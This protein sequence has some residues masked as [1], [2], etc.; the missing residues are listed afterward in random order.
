MTGL[1]VILSFALFLGGILLLGNAFLF[2]ALGGFI[3]F[4]GILAISL[5]LGVAFHI[6]P[7]SQ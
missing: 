3:F 6:L 7:K 2:P 1:G 4:G 5:S